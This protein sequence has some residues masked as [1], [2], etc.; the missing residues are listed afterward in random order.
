MNNMDEVIYRAIMDVY[1]HS[2]KLAV[3]I[4]EHGEFRAVVLI[5]GPEDTSHHA[6]DMPEILLK[7]VKDLQHAAELMIQHQKLKNQNIS[8]N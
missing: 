1:E 7:I 5:G 3:K 4:Y 6:E 2:D 8:V